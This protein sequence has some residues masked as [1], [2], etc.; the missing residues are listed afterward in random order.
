MVRSSIRETGG[1]LRKIA[2]LP[3]LLTLGNAV[4]GFAS[5][6]VASAIKGESDANADLYYMLSAV[7]IFG[8]MV[9][10]ASDGC[11]ARLSGSASDFGRH[12]DSLCDAV[13]FGVAPSFLLLCIGQHWGANYPGRPVIALIAGL[14]LVCAILR[15]ARYDV[16]SSP[17]PNAGMHF[18]GLPSM[19]AA[20]CVATLGLLRAGY[21]SEWHGL[22]DKVLAEFVVTWAPLGTLVVALLM[23]STVPFP[24]VT[25][26]LTQRCSPF[27]VLVQA[28]LV[29]F[30]IALTRGLALALLFWVYALAFPIRSLLVGRHQP[31]APVEI[32]RTFDVS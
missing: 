31:V 22:T 1:T 4:C 9:F 21:G 18:K 10:D 6:A 12:L 2:A 20:G 5:I 7:F 17:D 29:V 16:E 27:G 30:V 26:H 32:T 24:H 15:L 8:A 11:V 25:K 23:V 13:S 19:A 28:V 3:T 14:Y